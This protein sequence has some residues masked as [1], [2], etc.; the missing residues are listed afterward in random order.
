M[1]LSEMIGYLAFA[2]S[3]AIVII[4]VATIVLLR[5]GGLR[6]QLRVLR[7]L[8]G[9]TTATLLLNI[10]IV[11]TGAGTLATASFI[12]SILNV[13]LMWLLIYMFWAKGE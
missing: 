11:G 1:L 2:N 4:T 5:R 3:L 12:L 8:S 6:A 7:L 10:Y 13:V 9:Y